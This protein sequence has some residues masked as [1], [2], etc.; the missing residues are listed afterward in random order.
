ML[1][2]AI[3]GLLAVLTAWGPEWAAVANTFLLIILTLV[4][5]AK[6]RAAREERRVVQ[7]NTKEAV[8]A[9]AVIDRKVTDVQQKITSENRSPEARTRKD[10][11]PT[12]QPQ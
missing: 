2:P 7:H 6:E 3:F 11:P 9:A 8:K 10:D 1:T 12:W 5:A 4:T